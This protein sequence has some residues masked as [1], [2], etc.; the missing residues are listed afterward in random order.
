MAVSNYSVEFLTLQHFTSELSIAIS[1]DL[2]KVG[3]KLFAKKVISQVHL[4]KALLPTTVVSERAGELVT[5]VIAQVRL[6]SERFDIFLE[7][8]KESAISQK[9]LRDVHQKYEENK[10]SVISRDIRT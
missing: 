8:L 3:L 4:E 7:V 6:D 1:A 10:A 9:V 2:T 5:Q